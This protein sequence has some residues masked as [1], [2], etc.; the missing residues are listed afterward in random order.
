M[1]KISVIVPVYNVEK[2]LA[3]CLNS[4]LAQ[5]FADF[6]VICMNDGS[7]DKSADILNE[8]AQKDARVTVLSQENQG[9]S[10][11]RNHALQK[12]RGD[13]VFFLDSDDAI[14]PQTL[15]IVYQTALKYGADLVCFDYAKSDGVQLPSARFDVQKIEAKIYDKP[16]F[17][18]CRG[19][20]RIPFN[21]WTKFYKRELICGLEFI[22][23]I[24]FEDYPYTYAVLLKS[25]KTVVLPLKLHLYTKNFNSIS[26]QKARPKQIADYRC[27][28]MNVLAL[29][30]K[31]EYAKELDFFKKDGLPQ[32]LKHQYE[33]CKSACGEETSQMWKIFAEELAELKQ[34]KMLSWQGHNLWRYWQYLKLLKKFGK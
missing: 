22:P 20:N 5:T 30:D 16:F 11:A 32:L 9:L 13:Y 12:A 34:K 2:Y 33:K 1:P 27:G 29:L 3:R 15:E 10:A 23:G 25:P 31:P 26:H 17:C 18:G 14:E 8:F 21:V 6:E 24:Q 4:V 19:K 28:V 7:Q